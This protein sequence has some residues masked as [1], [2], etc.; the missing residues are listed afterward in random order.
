MAKTSKTIPQKEVAS[1]SQPAADVVTTEYPLEDFVPEG[2]PIV[3]NFKIE[4]T[5]SILGRC[6]PVSSY[7]YIITD[8]FLPKVKEDCNWVDKHVVVPS[9]EESITTHVKVF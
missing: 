7:I 8:Y 2:Y 6:E 9:P 5:S 3:T 1:S 4:K